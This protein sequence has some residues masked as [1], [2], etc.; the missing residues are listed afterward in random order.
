MITEIDASCTINI[1]FAIF[2]FDVLLASCY[3]NKANV[4]LA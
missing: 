4:L 3:L 1:Q 2:F